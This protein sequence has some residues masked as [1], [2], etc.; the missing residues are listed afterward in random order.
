MKRIVYRV[1][2]LIYR[3]PA[4]FT[5]G[6]I[7][8]VF[9]LQLARIF[10]WRG[11]VA[12]RSQQKLDHFPEIRAA[13]DRDGIVILPNFLPTEDHRRVA[14]Q[15]EQLIEQDRFR[16]LPR[17]AD[18]NIDHLRLKISDTKNN[19]LEWVRQLFYS[20]P[21]VTETLAYAARK[22]FDHHR[23][24]VLYAISR[25]D[26]DGPNNDQESSFH[27]DHFVPCAKAYYFINDHNAENGSYYY[28]KGSGGLEKWR[29]IYEYHLSILK[30]RRR[31]K[32]RMTQ[33]DNKG[34]TEIAL[35]SIR[36]R[37]QPEQIVAPANTLILSDNMGFHRRGDILSPDVDRRQLVISHR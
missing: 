22:S 9:G 36:R 31:R 15:F 11:L 17:R 27:S 14:E 34:V 21:E 6:L 1:K 23:Q 8:C 24:I 19:D 28:C 5:G 13:V 10:F 37:L 35:R 4:Y 16:N 3:A 30:A 26:M 20:R 18:T 32:G 25:T 7:F 33:S 2:S 12:L 29:L